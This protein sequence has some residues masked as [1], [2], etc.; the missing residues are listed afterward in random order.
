MSIRNGLFGNL[1]PG[2]FCPECNGTVKPGAIYEDATIAPEPGRKGNPILLKSLN[3]RLGHQ[4]PNDPSRIGWCFNCQ[5]WVHT[6]RKTT[7]DVRF[8]Y[9]ARE[10]VSFRFNDTVIGGGVKKAKSIASNLEA[11]ADERRAGSGMVMR[12]TPAK[13]RRQA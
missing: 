5:D 12:S 2:H 4:D 10:G 3:S 6:Y 7:I 13:K 8:E 11:R 1:W 9:A